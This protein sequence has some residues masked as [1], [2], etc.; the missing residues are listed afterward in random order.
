M[1]EYFLL[2][3]GAL[4]VIVVVAMVLLNGALARRLDA[5]REYSARVAAGEHGAR[6]SLGNR[7][8]PSRAG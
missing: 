7:R 4:V 1:L 5:L 3:L 2:G 8:H 6:I